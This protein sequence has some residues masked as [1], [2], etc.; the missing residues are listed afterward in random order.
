MK[1]VAADG[2]VYVTDKCVKLPAPRWDS[3]AYLVDGNQCWTTVDD[4][5]EQSVTWVTTKS[6]DWGSKEMLEMLADYGALKNEKGT[7]TDN[8][9]PSEVEKT[10]GDE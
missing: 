10:Q 3:Y 6:K 4:W 2:C 8:D 9:R 7:M 5:P 1:V